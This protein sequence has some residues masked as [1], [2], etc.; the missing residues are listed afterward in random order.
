M[1][2]LSLLIS[3]LFF[4]SNAFAMKYVIFTD[5]A[6]PK[7]AREVVEVMKNTYPFTKHKIEFEIV[8]VKENELNCGSTSLNKKGNVVKR[9]VTCPGAD[10]FQSW[11]SR[12]GGDQAMIIKDLDYYGGTSYAGGVPVMTTGSPARVMLHEYMHTLGLCDEYDYPE[13][14]ADDHCEGVVDAPNAAFFEPNPNYLNDEAARKIH[15][16]QIPWYADI[17]KTTKITTGDQLGTGTV[18]DDKEV[19]NNT[20]IPSALA[21]P[22]GLFKGRTCKNATKP[23][24]SWL[25]GG[26][27][28]VM[29][30]YEA[31][32]GAQMER[33]VDKI[34]KSKGTPVKFGELYQPAQVVQIESSRPEPAVNDSPRNFFKD[35]FQWFTDLFQGFGRGIGL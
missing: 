15:S 9:A 32:L 22:V 30:D 13:E 7:K 19:P 31:G 26:K 5:E 25:P 35:F 8:K 2:K 24:T 17:L 23:R 12:K 1:K 33:S 21:E 28:T 10:G 34:L 14:E 11:A 6:D 16:G 20:N 29:D 4:S 27:K 3:L 18:S